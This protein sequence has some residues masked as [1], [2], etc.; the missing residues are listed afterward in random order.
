MAAPTRVNL[1][2][3]GWRDAKKIGRIV[4]LMWAAQILLRCAIDMS[5]SLCGKWDPLMVYTI[6]IRLESSDRQ[7][8][9]SK[10]TQ[11]LHET[12]WMEIEA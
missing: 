11:S 5:G 1:I 12:L 9:K 7:R 4:R 2:H 6:Y 10:L 3:K 8:Q